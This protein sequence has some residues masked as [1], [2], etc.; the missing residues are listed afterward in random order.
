MTMRKW[1]SLEDALLHAVKD[2]FDAERQLLKV[3]PRIANAITR[4]DVADAAHRHLDES[5]HHVTRLEQVFAI[6]GEHPAAVRCSGAAGLVDEAVCLL[7]QEATGEVRDAA[8][9]GWMQR[10]EHYEIASYGTAAA[11]ADALE[12][13]GV[14]SLLRETLSEEKDADETL[15]IL[16]EAGVNTLA[17]GGESRAVAMGLQ[18]EFRMQN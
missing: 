15:T 13:D 6:L 2:L 14:A 7:A 8:I 4:E 9:V 18:T 1:V 16:A 10:A 11:W 3:L 17:I 5:R 12:F